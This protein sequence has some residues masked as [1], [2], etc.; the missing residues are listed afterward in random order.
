MKLTIDAQTCGKWGSNHMINILNIKG[1]F[2]ITIME[3]K[4]R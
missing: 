1:L 4:I 3:N 2:I